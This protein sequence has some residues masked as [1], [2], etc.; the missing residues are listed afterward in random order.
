MIEERNC[1]E[2][3]FPIAS[4]I[5]SII[6]SK[7][8]VVIHDIS[9]PE[10]SIVFIENGYISGR[11][12]GDSSTDLVL[13]LLKDES[14]REQPF[15]ANYKARGAQG[16][17]FRSA[18]YYIKNSSSELVGMMCINIDVT[19]MEVATEWIQNILQGGS[20]IPPVPL[21]PQQEVVEKQTE[22]YLQ[23][24][25]DDLLQHM[26]DSVLGKI[27]VPAERLSSQEKIDLVKVLNEQGVFLLKGGVSQVAK[28]LMI[29]EPTVYRYL[30]KIK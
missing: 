15:I 13:K 21:I 22:E 8:E 28:S 26:I 12:I 11:K 6:G 4:F 1:L 9:N 20:T 16:Q 10:R 27:N 17:V 2:A 18:T 19:H 29:S 3:Y 14:Y 25:V 23:G 30:Q 5:A 24:N 7:C